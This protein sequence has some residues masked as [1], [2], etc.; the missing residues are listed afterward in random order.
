MSEID[1]EFWAIRIAHTANE[2]YNLVYIPELG[3]E[4]K[5]EG[6]RFW[7]EDHWTATLSF[8]EA[9]ISDQIAH[10]PTEN[11]GFRQPNSRA[12]QEVFEQV[13]IFHTKPFNEWD[14]IDMVWAKNMV[15]SLKAPGPLYPQNEP[16][17][18]LTKQ[19][20]FNIIK[21][22]DLNL[23]WIEKL[24]E[25]TDEPYVIINHFAAIMQNKQ[26]PYMLILAGH[27]STGKSPWLKVMCDII[28]DYGSDQIASLGEK[29]GMST[30]Y[31]KNLNVNTEMN[32]AY[33][34]SETITAIKQVFSDDGKMN[35]RLLYKNPF[36]IEE[37]RLNIIG[38]TNQCAKLVEGI[39]EDGFFKRCCVVEC[40]KKK[41]ADDPKFLDW[42]KSEDTLSQIGS[43]LLYYKVENLRA[44]I[45]TN[46]WIESNKEK[47]YRSA[48][49]VLEFIK[50][51]FERCYEVD[52]YV[53][54]ESVR[55]MVQQEMMAQG[56]HLMSNLAAEVTHAMNLIGAEVVQRNK[57]K[58]YLGV[59]DKGVTIIKETT[60]TSVKYSGP[61]D[62]FDVAEVEHK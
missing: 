55:N 16:F 62:E 56:V 5:R 54:A 50:N 52:S 1:T 30:C 43:Y 24:K 23:D 20:N 60:P 26:L 57:T 7:Q 32:I 48:Y 38:A 59:R 58:C 45:G 31:D 44:V 46:K 39:D 13:K 37:A 15:Y 29:G 6:F 34:K 10:T 4:G 25:I 21:E 47:W 12:I 27:P 36:Q 53:T 18:Y 3:K 8:I 28:G 40:Y 14:K 22:E 9:F 35:V 19:R 49:P 42:L 2:L 17:L 61:L 51:R 33:I 11:G 41:F